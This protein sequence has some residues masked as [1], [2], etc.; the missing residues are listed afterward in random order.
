MAGHLRAIYGA[1][2]VAA[3]ALGGALAL[4][5]ASLVG[6]FG[7]TTTVREVAA[8]LPSPISLNE[9]AVARAGAL[10]VNAIYRHAAPGVVQ[11]TATQVVSTQS[12]DPF[13]FPFPAQQPSEA[14]GSGFVID[15]AGHIVTNYHVVEH[16]RSVDVSF[17]NNESL[18]A[19][20]V[21]A[22][23][24]TDI[25]VL[26]VDAHARALTPLALG[27][28]DAVRVGDSV[29]AIGNPFGYDRT[30][31]A[32]IV[33]A[34]QRVIRAPNSYS[35]DH[36]IQTDAALNK[37]N[38]GGPLLDALGNVIGVNSQIAAGDSGASGNVGIGFAVPI[39]TVKTV[40]AQ[41]IRT[42][43][44]EHAYLGISVQAVTPSAA[45][46]FHLPSTHGL[47]VASVQ[48]GSGAAKAGLLAGTG[49]ATLAGETYPL[50]GDLITKIDS[51][52]LYSLDQL[53]DV[54]GQKQP[55]DDTQLEVYRGNGQRTVTV[56]LG[57]QPATA[58]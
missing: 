49:N 3:G 47:L 41:I 23:P 10:S 54:I 51:T 35:I 55:G 8:P 2:L 30:V 38:S 45:K 34:L 17:S 20:V 43:H 11:V 18:K 9:P 14:L 58:S 28:S 33:S 32:G 39:N 29:V 6:D 5:G 53:R 50:G 22:D 12:V 36:V 19:K 25:A 37:G 16:A 31:T 13:G 7:T 44:A 27:N 15:K 52:S 42:G 57:R 48:P 46:L 4:G 26:Q 21:G 40:A 56:K 24:S 1:G